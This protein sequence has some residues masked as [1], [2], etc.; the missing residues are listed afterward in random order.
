[1]ILAMGVLHVHECEENAFVCQDC[2]EHVKHNAHISQASIM[3]FDC[4]LCKIIGTE[5]ITPEVQT[6]S[7]VVL[8]FAIVTTRTVQ[9]ILSRAVAL[10]SLRAPPAMSCL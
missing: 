1:M 2:M 10:P 5:Y 6:F 9:G 8:L 4:V 3:D 7:A